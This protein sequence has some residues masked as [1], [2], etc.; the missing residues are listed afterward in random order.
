MSVVVVNVSSGSTTTTLPLISSVPG[1]IITIKDSGSASVSNTITIVPTSGNTF[2]I[3]TYVINTP[4][5]YI[6]FLGFGTS[7]RVIATSYPNI[8]IYTS[9]ISTVSGVIGPANATLNTLTV[10]AQ[11]TLA[12]TSNTGTLGVAGAATFSNT[13][14]TGTLGVTGNAT[15][16]GFTGGAGTSFGIPNMLTIGNDSSTG[17]FNG[18]G[19]S[20]GTGRY[21]YLRH[22][23][24]N[25]YGYLLADYGFLPDTWN[26]TYNAYTSNGAW[27]IPN[28]DRGT[29]RFQMT[30]SSFVWLYGASNVAPTTTAM[31]LN[32]G[33]L[34]VS[35]SLYMS[36]G[37]VGI[38]VVSAQSFTTEPNIENNLNNAPTNG[39]GKT[40]GFPGLS[41]Y[42]GSNQQP[43][44]ITGYYGINFVGGTGN[45][46]TGASHMSIVDGKVGIQQKNPQYALDV[47]GTVGI[48][49]NISVGNFGNVAWNASTRG[50]VRCTGNG[51]SGIAI[52]PANNRIIAY[53]WSAGTIQPLGITASS[54]SLPT[55]SAPLLNI[56]AGSWCIKDPNGAN[57]IGFSNAAGASGNGYL[58]YN[59]PSGYGHQWYTNLGATMTL[60]PFG[61]LN[62]LRY[63]AGGGNMTARTG[64]VYNRGND[65]YSSCYQSINWIPGNYVSGVNWNRYD[66]IDQGAAGIICGAYLNTAIIEF[67]LINNPSGSN[68]PIRKGYFNNDGFFATSKNFSIEHPTV[69]SCTLVHASIEGP[70]YDLIYRNRKQ[71]VNG[72]AEVDIEKESTANGSIMTPG[73]FDAL[74]TNSQVFLQNNDSFD[75]VKGFVSSHMLFIQCEN[76]NS[77]AFIDWM[78]T[79][80]RHDKHLINSGITDASGFL[81]LEHYVSTISSTPM[82]TPNL[83]EVSTPSTLSTFSTTS[84]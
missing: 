43:L 23:L 64:G 42:S 16:G 15:F 65:A 1:G 56:T 53:D 49:S 14:N 82:P 3:G 9:T 28:V 12:N 38:G 83:D 27:V 10:A 2:Q 62:A 22:N 33:G 36:L 32:N 73:T 18:S 84:T 37:A 17:F 20:Y 57:R 60:D 45:W 70:R 19:I 50:E 67:W 30:S 25:V 55:M 48:T 41:T 52:D 59:S 81:I 29:T 21:A 6:T 71:L 35:G 44:Q 4:L 77:S 72:L 51:T 39:M 8:P 5:G 74:A 75:R 24:G 47:N 46:I 66:T 31:T 7:W 79:A 11:T 68:P 69:S 13:S 40:I 54:I 34:S 58:Q 61:S 26:M 76:L 78:V 80:E 63:E